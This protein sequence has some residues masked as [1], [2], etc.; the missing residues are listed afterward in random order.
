MKLGLILGGVFIIVFICIVPLKRDIDEYNVQKTGIEVDAIITD[1][2]N[3][4][5][6]KVKHFLKFKF[7]NSIYSKRVGAPCDQ[8]KR[9]QVIRLKHEPGTD[10]FLYLNETKESEFVATAAMAIFGILLIIIGIK[11][12]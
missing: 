10:I 11:K 9:G 6:T 8:Y 2:P 4:F 3:C 7:E 12:K 5:G 1:V